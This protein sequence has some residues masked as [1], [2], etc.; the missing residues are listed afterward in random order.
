MLKSRM[1]RIER[2]LL[3]SPGRTG[4]GTGWALKR[5]NGILTFIWTGRGPELKL[6]MKD[7]KESMNVYDAP[8][9]TDTERA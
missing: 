3:G 5:I 6:S 8:R 9:A 1:D 4:G 7:L 2:R